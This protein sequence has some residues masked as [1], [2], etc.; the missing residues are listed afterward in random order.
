MTPNL[1]CSRRDCLRTM[2]TGLGLLALPDLL[3]A[4]N[5]L[6]PKQPHFAA[7]A[8]HIIHVYLNGGPSHV[9]TWDPK[10]ELTKWGGKRL[11]IQLT[12]ERE[13]GVALASPFRF[14][15][16]GESGLWCSEVFDRTASQHA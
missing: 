4:A 16:H 2:G 1:S 14:K 3:H 13:T 7:R 6:A 9:D 10:P 15:Q 11:P 8:K 12:T 5:P